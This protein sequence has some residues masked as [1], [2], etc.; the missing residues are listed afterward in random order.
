MVINK[1]AL[2]RLYLSWLLLLC[3]AC[4]PDYVQMASDRTAY[5]RH[6]TGDI[7]VAVIKSN[8][9]DGYLN[10][11]QLAA[12]QI[13]QRPDRLLDRYLRLSIWPADEG[14][15][16]ANRRKILNIAADPKVVA[17]LGHDQSSTAIPASVVYEESQMIFI[18]SFATS[19]SLTRH[20]FRYV[21]RMVPNSPVLADQATNVAKTF[22]YQRMVVLHARDNV[23]RELAFL[24]E[25]A[26]VEKGIK[27]VKRASF[28]DDTFD[29]RVLISE[30]T[31]LSFDAIFLAAP[32]DSAARLARQL[33]EM[34]LNQ[35]ILGGD[36]I[37][38]SA[39]VEQ[40][41]RT[42]SNRTILP[43]VYKLSEKSPI[44]QSFAQAYTEK[45]GTEPDLFAALGYDSVMLLATAI[46]R[47]ES[48][49]A[50][51]VSSTL[52][53]MPPFVGVTGVHAFDETGD[54]V[55]G[56][57]YFFQVIRDGELHYLSAI[58][59][60]YLLSEFAQSLRAQRG[61]DEPFTDFLDKF[62]HP[63]PDEDHK[64]YLLDLAHEILRFDRIGI[65]YE[66][67]E[68]GRKTA[69]YAILQQAAEQKGFEILECRIP[70]S[71]LDPE[72]IKQELFACYGKLSLEIDALFV[73][74][75]YD[76]DPTLVR[77]L[78]NSL[79]FYKIPS[80]AFSGRINPPE[81]SLL[82]GRRSDIVSGNQDSMSLYADLLNGIK[83]HQFFESLSGLPEIIMNIDDVSAANGAVL[84]KPVDVYLQSLM[85]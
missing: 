85:N 19:Q 57:K 34:G 2:R 38:G 74:S 67:T 66:N 75:Y 84:D 78:H 14:G 42:A 56:K 5:A 6:N 69:D 32:V 60:F 58:E 62:T 12:E 68:Q 35:P 39:Y 50:S 17:V 30:L 4:S 65:I 59:Q 3:V 26:A 79:R 8:Y 77:Y 44:D 18:C 45:H 54:D 82:L 83:M 71:F 13:N 28:F 55:G 49:V 41:G 16:T 43:T 11:A 7:K 1:L 64:V 46:E 36:D 47:T 40:A 63:V 61:A 51:A 81:V 72:Q 53:Y 20:D 21:F 25:D 15:F 48:T 33:R 70:F 52:H 29:Y 24:F 76:T 22:G 31:K 27:L 9:S 10:G 73:S 23:N 37:I 80:V